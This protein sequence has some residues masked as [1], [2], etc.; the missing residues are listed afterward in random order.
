MSAEVNAMHAA[1]RNSEWDECTVRYDHGP[2][3]HYVYRRGP[4]EQ[5]FS[6][7]LVVAPS[8]LLVSVGAHDKGLYAARSFAEGQLIGMYNGRVVGH[9]TSREEALDAPETQR[10]ARSGADKLVTVRPSQGGG[11]DLIDGSHGTIPYVHLCNDPHRTRRTP[12]CE[13]TPGGYLRALRRIPAFDLGRPLD[14]GKNRRAELLICYGDDFWL[15]FDRLGQSRGH[16]IEL[17]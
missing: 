10:L 1:I 2:R 9:Y 8:A 16:P 12:N 3:L 15:L 17:D 14:D 7:W 5:C 13:L 6:P 11:V 4:G